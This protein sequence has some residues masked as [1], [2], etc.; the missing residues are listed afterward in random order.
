MAVIF[1]LLTGC[2]GSA[3]NSSD[4]GT[5]SVSLTPVTPTGVSPES[6]LRPRP[7]LRQ[8]VQALVVEDHFG[9]GTAAFGS[10]PPSRERHPV[11][12]TGTSVF[13]PAAGWRP[14]WTVGVRTEPNDG[15]RLCEPESEAPGECVERSDGA[16]LSW[17][18]EHTAV[19]VPRGDRVVTAWMAGGSILLPTHLRGHAWPAIVKPLVSLA[20]D[21]R[22]VVPPDP[23]LA[24][25]ARDYPRW[26]R[27]PTC[28]RAVPTGPVPVPP[29]T[30]GPAEPA[31][32]QALVALIAER[33]SGT[34]AYA[35]RRPDGS[36]VR[37]TVYL[38]ADDGEY[39]SATVTTDPGVMSCDGFGECEERDGV[40]VAWLLDVPE[41]YPLRVRLSRP[42]EGGYLV[43]E[44]ASRQADPDR[45]AFPVPLDTLLALVR[46]ER[47]GFAVDP[48]LILAGDELPLCWRL[49]TPTDD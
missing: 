40:T 20:T 24:A 23:V 44:H 7:T 8:R 36:S 47:A 39:V 16:V 14:A 19:I 12:H 38:T 37:G 33:V 1:L 5:A 42:V 46:D 21:S 22:L 15:R 18:G 31:T 9:A 3:G 32:P 17:F 35:D 4:P 26:T 11:R 30:G 45:R 48:S 28:A 13:H 43:V 10:E 34:C 29:A 27:D 49:L 25:E 41:E 2:Q 6:L